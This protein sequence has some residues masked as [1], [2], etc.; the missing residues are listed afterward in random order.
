M[1]SPLV[2]WFG[3]T[4]CE[5]Y[6][7][8]V[9]AATA[10]RVVPVVGIGLVGAAGDVGRAS[11][12]TQLIDQSLSLGDVTQLE[13]SSLQFITQLLNGVL[14]HLSPSCCTI[15]LD[16]VDDVTGVLGCLIAQRID[17]AVGFAATLLSIEPRLVDVLVDAV[18]AGAQVSLYA[19]ESVQHAGI[20]SVEAITQTIVDA[21]QL[22]DD[23]LSVEATL[24]VCISSQALAY[25]AT[26]AVATAEA[27]A[28]T[29]I[30]P[31]Q[32]EEQEEYPASI[33]T[34]EAIVVTVPA[35]G[36]QNRFRRGNATIYHFHSHSYTSKG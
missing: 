4:I 23:G 14:S 26:T 8:L 35:I 15:F 36:Q 13:L 34:K 32:K 9:A 1:P 27:V 2:N 30:A 5:D 12:G 11:A 10:A 20:H 22:T 7:G 31:G 33:T 25:H 3:I 21:I 29:A 18:E 16:S 24:Q 28:P 6:W 19:I 17:I